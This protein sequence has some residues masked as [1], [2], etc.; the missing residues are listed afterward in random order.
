MNTTTAL[1]FAD[2]LQ[3]I[4]A[5]KKPKKLTPLQEEEAAQKRVLRGAGGVAGMAAGTT[6][7]GMLALSPSKNPATNEN[8]AAIKQHMKV[9]GPVDV[10]R[11]GMFDFGMSGR[12]SYAKP[13]EFTGQ[14]GNSSIFLGRGAG[15]AVAAHEMGHVKNWQKAG[16][17]VMGRIARYANLPARIRP[18]QQGLPIGSMAYSAGADD[19]SLTPA[20]INA[21]VFAPALVDEAMA[22]GRAVGYMTK[23]HGLGKG[24]MRSSKL[25]P[26]F[27]TYATMAGA[28]LAV[29]AYR[30]HKNKGNTKKA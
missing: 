19:P 30:H 7:L 29:A 22:S 9:R 23:K 27:G 24:L 11:P 12:G 21:G 25:L 16:K 15:E 20:A 18:I 13:R 3:K 26:A 1:A 8:V 14:K 4:A 5:A 17:G 10:E 28:P 6:G 2:E